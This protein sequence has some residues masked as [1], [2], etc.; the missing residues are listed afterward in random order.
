[1]VSVTKR[2]VVA[3]YRAYRRVVVIV[4]G[5]TLFLLVLTLPFTM[6]TWK[7]WWDPY[8]AYSGI[9]VEKR[10]EFRLLDRPATRVGTFVVKKK[11]FGNIRDSP[12]RKPPP[13]SFARPNESR[14]RRWRRA[15]QNP[16]PH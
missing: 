1:V 9:V 2:V 14:R 11:S 16:S 4:A 15:E 7:G 8:S 13:S 6:H 3:S 12:G 10:S 5:T